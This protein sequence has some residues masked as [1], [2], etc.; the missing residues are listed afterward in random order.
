MNH[1]QM[2]AYMFGQSGYGNNPFTYSEIQNDP[3]SDNA[4]EG[5]QFNESVP[6]YN[7]IASANTN[8]LE[9]IN[10]DL[11]KGEQSTA[12]ENNV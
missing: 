6:Y 3:N 2:Q 4:R 12:R 9:P 5:M 11:S 7:H 10:E 1:L 8:E